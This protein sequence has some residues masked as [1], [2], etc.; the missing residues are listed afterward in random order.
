MFKKIETVNKE[1]CMKLNKIS[2]GQF[3]NKLFEGIEFD[4]VDK[5]GSNEEIQKQYDMLK[6]YTTKM[7]SNNFSMTKEYKYASKSNTGRL[8]V[9]DNGLQRLHHKIRGVL[10]DGLYHDFDMVNAHPSILLYLCKE[11]SFS[12]SNLQIYISSRDECITNLMND[13]NG[14]R[15][16]AKR[17]FL[18]SMN[19]EKITKKYKDGNRWFNIKDSFFIKLDQEFKQIQKLFLNKYEDIKRELIKKGIGDNLQGKVL[20]KVLCIYENIILQESISNLDSHNLIDNN[21]NIVLMF[22]GFMLKTDEKHNTDNILNNLNENQYDV[23]W[24]LKDHNISIYD[25]LQTINTDGNDNIL[26]GCFETL[27]DIG[28]YLNEALFKDKLI[29]SNGTLYFNDNSIL[30][31]NEKY[32]KNVVCRIIKEQDLHYKYGNAI[33]DIKSDISNIT[34]IYKWMLFDVEEKNKFLDDIWDNTIHKI[35]FKNGYYDFRQ[36]KFIT[37][38]DKLITPIVIEKD[39]DMKS[40]KKIREEIFKR[41]LHPIFDVKQIGD[42]NF[43]LMEYL[44][45]KFA[46]V[47]SGHIED[48]NWFKFEGL[49]DSGKGVFSDLMKNSFGKYIQ[50]TNASNFI[51]KKGDEDAKSLS[52]LLD[53]RFSRLAITQE[54]ELEKAKFIDGNKIKKFNSGGDYFSARKNFKD[55][56]EFKIQSALLICCNDLPEIKPSD[57]LQKCIS[58]NMPSIFV[59]DVE[60]KEY[61]NFSYYKADGTIKEFIKKDE[62]INEFILMMIEY[63]NK[64]KTEY[65]KTILEKSG[66]L[67]EEEDEKVLINLFNM[68]VSVAQHFLDNKELKTILTDNNINITIKKAKTLLIGKGAKNHRTKTGRGLL[69]LQLLDDA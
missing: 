21:K 62:V 51:N 44:L 26:S 4:C 69:G 35:C 7:V 10:S 34:D 41:V 39:L 54:I 22:D 60:K 46:R 30:R 14:D 31:E 48:K 37:D 23:K 64:D 56:I 28:K 29:V 3:K 65:P 13:I 38:Y 58:F 43:K 20:N 47:V 53:F 52:W 33:I 59:K 24:S 17:L 57:A 50:Y 9:K 6:K 63:Y 66:E 25:N 18:Q 2:F 1:V 11:H 32:I 15:N 61:S 36:Q 16:S 12:C 67:E 42:D 27:H 40:N 68:D 8:F 45:H 49:R 19:S 5:N 55:E